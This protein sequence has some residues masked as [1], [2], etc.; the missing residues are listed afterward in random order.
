MTPPQLSFSCR[1]SQEVLMT[2]ATF[3]ILSKKQEIRAGSVWSWTH[4]DLVVL[5]WELLG[6]TMPP[7]H[8]IL[9]SLLRWLMKDIR[10]QRSW[11]AG[12]PWEGECSLGAKKIQ[13]HAYFQNDSLE[14]SSDDWRKCRS[15]RRHDCFFSV[16]SPCCFWFYWMLYSTTYFQQLYCKELG[17]YGETVSFDVFSFILVRCLF[18]IF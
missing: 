1:E 12:F 11:D 13:Q 3:S 9:R 2:A 4:E 8:M 16:G 6:R 10:M 7:L 5:S 14:L 18:L 15:G 17:R